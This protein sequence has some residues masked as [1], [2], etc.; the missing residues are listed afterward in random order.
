MPQKDMPWIQDDLLQLPNRQP[1]QVGS[2]AWFAW[3][4]EISTFCYQ[5][6]H[7]ID[8]LTIR[9]EKR[10]HQFYWYAYLRNDRKLHNAYVGK[11]KMVTKARLQKVHATL[12]AKVWRYRQAESER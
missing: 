5:P 9:K 8:R 12:T 10:R 7:N 6:P 2:K 11:T 1:I 3:L 4:E